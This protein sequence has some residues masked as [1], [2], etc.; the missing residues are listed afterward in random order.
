MKGLFNIIIF[1]F[2]FL[3]FFI[4][5][6]N[7]LKK[8]SETGFA[9]TRVSNDASIMYQTHTINPRTGELFYEHSDW[10]PL[11]EDMRTGEGDVI[12]TGVDSS[13]DILFE[14][15]IGLRIVQNSFIAL[16]EDV[17]GTL[18]TPR[19]V[20]T[21]EM[22]QLVSPAYA[23]NEE[24][25]EGPVRVVIDYGKVLGRVVGTKL[26]RSRGNADVL[27]VATPVTVA[28][29]RGTSFLV[30]YDPELNSSTIAV[31]DGVVQAEI[32]D[33]TT[34]AVN[35]PQGK[36]VLVTPDVLALMLQEITPAEQDEL[37]LTRKVKIEIG[38]WEKLG[39]SMD[40][41]ILSLAYNR[42]LV[43]ITR[44]EM[45]IFVKA[46][47][48][49]S[50]MKWGGEVPEILQDIGIEGGDY[51]DP[52][53]TDYHYKKYG[54]TTAILRSAGPDRIFYTRDD[55]SFWVVL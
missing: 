37:E 46:V 43:A 11:K 12:K 44:Y 30:D 33:S 5:V 29:I 23:G 10:I 3:V 17:N 13:V 20:S 16:P 6:G 7:Y 14:T 41:N 24:S 31:L 39:K 19:P 49:F 4:I 47:L 50:R 40:L 36:K 9:I 15:G 51:S 32:P 42:A 22:F 2:S 26:K 48:D 27:R 25:I 55:I 38:F 35:V 34:P 54:P 52:W 1:I 45:K 8:D 53:N 18:V 28:G 21:V